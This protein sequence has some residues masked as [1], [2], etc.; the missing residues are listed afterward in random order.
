MK[1]IIIKD[2]RYIIE[3]IQ[4]YLIFFMFLLLCI[5][6]HNNII[7]KYQINFI[8]NKKLNNFWRKNHIIN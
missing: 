4:I 3:K 5:N 1:I 7:K 2:Y 6:I 8:K